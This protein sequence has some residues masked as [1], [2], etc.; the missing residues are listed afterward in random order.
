MYL[1]SLAAVA[2][3]GA[4]VTGV[5][6][7]PGWDM[8]LRVASVLVL[9]AFLAVL[10][11]RSSRL[12]RGRSGGGRALA[13]LDVLPLGPQRGIYL[14]RVGQRGLVVGVTA[15]YVGLLAEI[16]PEELAQLMG[17]W[18]EE[19]KG[20]KFRKLLREG[21]ERSGREESPTGRDPKEGHGR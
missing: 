18:A 10:L 21:L 3:P 1:F 19:D 5:S 16:G 2:R 6:P 9:L 12:L 7:L 11:R 14:L 17:G 15:Q 20:D 4:P 13:L 8:F